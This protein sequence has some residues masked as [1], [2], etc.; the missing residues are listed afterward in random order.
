MYDPIA[1][2]PGSDTHAA[3]RF[4]SA[5]VAWYFYRYWNRERRAPAF[6][7]TK[8]QYRVTINGRSNKS[9]DASG[10]SVFLNLL[11]A[12]EGALIRA[13]A[14]TLSLCLSDKNEFMVL[15]RLERAPRVR[16][17]TLG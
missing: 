7:L 1:T 3:R 10:G 13:A 2:A 8:N 4:V 12:A 15:V 14:S 17:G 6:L 9:L 11:G 5:K 16:G